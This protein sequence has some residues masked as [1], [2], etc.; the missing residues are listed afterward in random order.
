MPVL[1][2]IDLNGNQVRS[3]SLLHTQRDDN[4]SGKYVHCLRTQSIDVDEGSD[5]K[6][7][8]SQERGRGSLT[9]ETGRDVQIGS[10]SLCSFPDTI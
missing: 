1:T 9:I 5:K 4:G 7:V 8:K 10:W 6:N 2:Q 3:E